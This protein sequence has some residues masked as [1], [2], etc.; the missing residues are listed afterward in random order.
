MFALDRL[1]LSVEFVLVFRVLIELWE[2]L[3]HIVY[4]QLRQLLV[5]L[6]H[7]AEEFAVIVVDYIRKIFLEWKW[8]QISPRHRPFLSFKNEDLVVKLK[9]LRS[10][11][12]HV[13]LILLDHAS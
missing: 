1:Y 6:K 4:E 7:E 8:L 9:N 2:Y 10:L 13:R 11:S 12:G 5:R 3:S